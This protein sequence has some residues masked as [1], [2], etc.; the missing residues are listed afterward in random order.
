LQNNPWNKDLKKKTIIA[1]S[2]RTEGVSSGEKKGG[3]KP[4]RKG[5][6]GG[7]EGKKGLSQQGR[8]PTPGVERPLFFNGLGNRLPDGKEKGPVLSIAWSANRRGSLG[9]RKKKRVARR[10]WETNRTGRVGNAL[11]N[12]GHK[13]GVLYAAPEGKAVAEEGSVPKG[14]RLVAEEFGLVQLQKGGTTPGE[15][16]RENATDVTREGFCRSKWDSP[17]HSSMRGKKEKQE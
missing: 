1:Y 7:E 17:T 6:V 5:T 12:W 2:Q 9:G 11:K 15:R 13:L 4:V 3:G 10:D 16:E 8:S 14:R